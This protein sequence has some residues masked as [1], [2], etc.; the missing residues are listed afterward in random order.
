MP[1]RSPLP[2]RHGL[3][4]AWLRTPD[5][6]QPRP[7]P[8]MRAY[9]VERLG[10]A[11]PVEVDRM[12]AAEAFVWQ[13]GSSVGAAEPVPPHQFVWFH[14]ELREEPTV[15][16]EVVVLHRDDRIVVV[17]KPP[18]LS[19]IPRGRHVTESV[20]VRLRHQLG[21]PELGPAHRLDRLTSGVLLL[22]T[23]RR[24]RAPYQSMFERR[25]PVKTYLALA[26]FRPELEWPRTVCSHIIKERGDR[27]AHEIAGLSPNAETQLELVTRVG[28]R[29]LYRLRPRTGRTHQ[30]RVQLAGLGIPIQ[31][32][33]LYP[34]EQEVDID[35]FSTPLQL[36]AESLSF[37]DPVDG[38]E[39][40]FRSPR[41]LPLRGATG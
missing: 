23:E 17:D 26:G 37:I 29:G 2:P 39:C 41:Q 12:L 10:P 14:R 38:R 21:L 9:L 31:G 35:D 27:Q 11:G 33:P 1:P 8:T 32:D 25:E 28:E 3:Q 36:L 19:S 16:G 4:A 24:W 30:L 20:V 6:G 13:D 18:F 22:T 15:P 7:W 40:E 5:H 34:V